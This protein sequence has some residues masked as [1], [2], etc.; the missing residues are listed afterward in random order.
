LEEVLSRTIDLQCLEE[1]ATALRAGKLVAIPTETVYG[2]AADATQEEAV[3]DIFR[4]KGR[5]SFNPLITHFATTHEAFSHVVAS[6]IASKLAQAFWPG[7]LTLVLERSPS[8]NLAPSIG[9]GLS[10]LAVRVPAHP[11]ALALL[12]HTARPLAAPSANP[13]EGLS[14]TCAQHVRDAFQ[15]NPLLHMVIDGGPCTQGLESTVVS[16]MGERVTVLRLGSLA[17]EDIEAV[18]G[19]P[20][21]TS[22]HTGI[23]SPGQMLR[24]YAPKNA[25][26]RLNACHVEEGEALLAFGPTTLTAPLMRNLSARADLQEAAQN[27]FAMLHE[28]DLAGARAIAVMPLPHIH[29]GAALNDRLVRASRPPLH[30]LS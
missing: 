30:P 24:H 27:L 7:P 28:L 12:S 5:P 6:P 1:A 18:L 9:A 23:T 13:S 17:H 10:T 11:V 14:P 26:I 2:L 29:V 19:M 15:G 4:L 8:S 21:K 20:L 25:R 3:A 22:K 16:V